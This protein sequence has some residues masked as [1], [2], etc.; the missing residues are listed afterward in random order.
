M[1]SMMGLFSCSLVLPLWWR[2]TPVAAEVCRSQD[3][4]YWVSPAV[5]YVCPTAGKMESQQHYHQPPAVPERH[6]L[7]GPARGLKYHHNIKNS[8]G[9][10]KAVPVYSQPKSCRLLLRCWMSTNPE[11][12]ISL[13]SHIMQINEKCQMIS[14]ISDVPWLGWEST[15][16]ICW[17]TG[18]LHHI[19]PT[20]LPGEQRRRDAPSPST[21]TYEQIKAG[22]RWVWKQ[23]L[24][25]YQRI[26]EQHLESINDIRVRK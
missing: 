8:R 18:N 13:I 7:E 5:V 20:A 15:V 22:A 26:N 1:I 4:M 21:L 9:T 19:W 3:L 2:L 12:R 10:L 11:N 25:I 14:V 24:H 6:V 16:E 17:A 23:T